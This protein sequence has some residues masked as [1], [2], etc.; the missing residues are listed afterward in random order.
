MLN[1]FVDTDFAGSRTKD[2]SS[3]A[4]SV[5]SQTGFTI[6]F[7]DCPILWTSIILSEIALSTTRAEYILLSQ[8]MCDVIPIRTILEDLNPTQIST[9]TNANPLLYLGKIK[10][11]LISLKH[12]QCTQSMPYLNQIS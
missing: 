10:D 1:C 6:T 4:P 3:E 7:A 8:A 5:H 12:L 9:Q 11:V 2:N